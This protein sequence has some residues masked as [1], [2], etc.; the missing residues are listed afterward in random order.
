MKNK[1]II[2]ARILLLVYAAMV[3]LL[4][5]MRLGNGIDM[6]SEWLGIPKDKIAHF[7]LFFPFPILMYA[8]FHM[9]R[10]KPVR[11]ILF[12]LLTLVIG[13]AAGAG[14]ELIQMTTDYRSCDILDFRADCIGLL[15]G[16]IL[17][18][19]YGAASRKW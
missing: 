12:L 5:F 6:S 15:C 3:C 17:V 13:A 14:I 7:F 1:T 2:I 9:H 11:L 10:S 4:C 8:A 16:S 18:M 19:I